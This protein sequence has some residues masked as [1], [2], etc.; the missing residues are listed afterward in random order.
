[1]EIS[2]AKKFF[3]KYNLTDP[4]SALD[5]NLNQEGLQS[6]FTLDQITQDYQQLSEQD[7]F[8]VFAH[9]EDAGDWAVLRAITDF[10]LTL[11]QVGWAPY[12]HVSKEIRKLKKSLQSQ[13]GQIWSQRLS[14]QSALFRLDQILFYSATVL[15][16][17][18]EAGL[19]HRIN[20][21]AFNHLLALYKSREGLY[22]LYEDLWPEKSK[23]PQGNPLWDTDKDALQ[24]PEHLEQAFDHL[25][26]LPLDSEAVLD[27]DHDGVPDNFDWAPADSLQWIHMNEEDDLLLLD[28]Y[29]DN[30]F[31][32]ERR[33]PAKLTLYRKDQNTYVINRRIFVS[34]PYDRDRPDRQLSDVISNE[35]LTRMKAKIE[36]SFRESI[37]Y[38]DSP[39]RFELEIEWEPALRHVDVFLN[40]EKQVRSTEKEWGPDVM[41]DEGHG[42]LH[43]ILHMT[44]DLPDLYHEFFVEGDLRDHS[45]TPGRSALIQSH[46][47]SDHNEPQ[48]KISFSEI[49]KALVLKRQDRLKGLEL[50]IQ[51]RT[52]N[53]DLNVN[54]NWGVL[55]FQGKIQEASLAF[56]TQYDHLSI[57]ECRIQF[58]KVLA[59]FN[60]ESS[61]S[62]FHENVWPL[63]NLNN[64]EEALVLLEFPDKTQEEKFVTPEMESM[65]S[66]WVKHYPENMW[67]HAQLFGIR[68]T[69][70]D[71]AGARESLE[72]AFMSWDIRFHHELTTFDK[73]VEILIGSIPWSYT[74]RQFNK[75]NSG[76]IITFFNNW[77]RLCS[78]DY[79]YTRR[80]LPNLI[81]HPDF[82]RYYTRLIDQYR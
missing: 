20:T 11:K 29:D 39:I 53:F 32:N 77:K 19:N 45:L 50:A 15:T 59:R 14:I 52:S 41:N 44:L 68:L 13:T 80:H 71:H 79:E 78:Y 62:Y 30:A 66:E 51:D 70:G 28:P 10:D 47:M 12:H 43:E 48:D 16:D 5:Q 2:S 63:I 22:A 1:M 61:I 26:V 21:S 38:G 72:N 23:Y 55:L 40:P 9:L 25:D 57:K 36:K 33:A 31:I 56:E 27:Q 34:I 35:T 17:Y 6:D 42:L 18:R 37:D 67:V 4:K 81:A 7:R 49:A 54:D 82:Q 65:L 58:A 3:T 74:D 64:E 75:T 46:I 73:F 69:L 24:T 8:L 76:N 60:P